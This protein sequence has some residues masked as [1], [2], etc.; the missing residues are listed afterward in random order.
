MAAMRFAWPCLLVFA[1]DQLPSFY[2]G[3]RLSSSEAL[4]YCEGSKD[5]ASGEQCTS[6]RG[7]CLGTDCDD[8]GDCACYGVCEAARRVAGCEK[9]EENGR[10]CQYCWDDAGEV[11]EKGCAEEADAEPEED[12]EASAEPEAKRQPEPGNELHAMLARLAQTLMGDDLDAETQRHVADKLEG[13]LHEA[14]KS[15]ELTAEEWRRYTALLQRARADRDR[16]DAT[17]GEQD[18][19][20]HDRLDRDR[21]AADDGTT[22]QATREGRQRR[23][24][25]E[26]IA[27]RVRA[28]IDEMEP[29]GLR[30]AAEM[31]GRTLREALVNVRISEDEVRHYRGLIAELMERA[32]RLAPACPCDRDPG[33]H[34]S[35]HD[36]GEVH[37]EGGDHRRP[38]E[39]AEYHCEDSD[40]LDA[41]RRGEIR[42]FD[43]EQRFHEGDSCVGRNQV[44]EYWCTDAGRDFQARGEA[45]LWCPRGCRDGACQ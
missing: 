33:R 44:R 12:A 11:I 38:P 29:R 36:C 37:R 2:Y 34:H 16:P 1:C 24:E 9:Y 10:D 20:G 30:R 8:A 17:Q 23:V 32:E 43:G 15:G 7:E 3:E 31:L 45:L 13:L 21:P 27:A 35:G 14:R 42:G 40:G 28:H 18:G 39:R 6:E 26:E 25:L 22:T 19:S 4:V 41:Y 5:C